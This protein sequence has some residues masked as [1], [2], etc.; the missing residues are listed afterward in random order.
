M[1]K[2]QLMS[3]RGS[4]SSIIRLYTLL[5]NA[6]SVSKCLSRASDTCFTDSAIISLIWASLSV[7]LFM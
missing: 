6:I 2:H 1:T 7:I 3:I 4:S 5:G